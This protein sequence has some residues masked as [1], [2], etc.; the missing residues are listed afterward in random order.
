VKRPFGG[1]ILLI[2]RKHVAA[3]VL[4]VAVV[5]IFYVVNHPGLVG[6]TARERTLPIYSVQRDDAVMSLTFNVTAAEDAYTARVVQ[7]LNAYGVRATFFVTG[8]WV[9]ENHD[10]AARLVEGGHELMNLSDDHSRLRKLPTR[11]MQANI[12]ACSD[13]IKAVAGER[14]IVFR[15][16][17]GEYDD[18]VVRLVEAVGMRTV[19][20]SVDSGDWRGLDAALIADQVQSRAASGAIVLLHSNL[21]QTALAMPVLIEGLLQAGYT[22]VP[23]SELVSYR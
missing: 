13:A 8:D 10:L 20:W 1:K 14:P 18:K 9:R 6:A 12:L 4:C 17:Y 19:Q 11:E 15:A 5:A 7:T 22:L 16:P 2:R 23:V 3:L 21:K